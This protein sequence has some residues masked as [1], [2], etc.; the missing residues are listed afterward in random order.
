[1]NDF[2]TIFAGVAFGNIV[3]IMIAT[4]VN[5]YLAKREDER[6]RAAFEADL[7]RY[8]SMLEKEVAEKPKVVVKRAASPAR[9]KKV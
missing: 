5:Q 7:K 2:V 1:M 9:T 6:R 8:E 3:S 4:Y